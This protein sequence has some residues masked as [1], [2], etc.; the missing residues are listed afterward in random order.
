MLRKEPPR[1]MGRAHDCPE[2]EEEPEEERAAAP[3]KRLPVSGGKHHL[4]G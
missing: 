3:P 1:A 4:V 2:A